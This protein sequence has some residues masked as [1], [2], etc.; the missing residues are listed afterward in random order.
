MEEQT[1]ENASL[2]DVR[3]GDYVVW[4]ESSEEDR[5]VTRTVRREGIAHHRDISGDWCTEEDLWITDGEGTTI[6]IRRPIEAKEAAK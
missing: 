1:I 5:G 2:D 6:T 3:P 4:E